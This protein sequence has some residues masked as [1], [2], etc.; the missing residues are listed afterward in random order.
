MRI[1]KKDLNIIDLEFLAMQSI[2]LYSF[3]NRVNKSPFP[4]SVLKEAGD[5]ESFYY[6]I[7][8]VTI[9]DGGEYEADAK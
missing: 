7:N 2:T 1:I 6:K 9:Y 8:G 4:L 3:I 5:L